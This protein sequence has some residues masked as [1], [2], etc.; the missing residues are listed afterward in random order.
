MT[1]RA[2]F[3]RITN[4]TCHNF[5]EPPDLMPTGVKSLLGLGLKYCIKAPKPTNKID[6]T[7]ERLR[8]DV[9]RIA[10]LRFNPQHE[11]P[12]TTYIPG[13]YLKTDW[14]ADPTFPEIEKCL[15]N[16][17]TEIRRTRVRYNQPTLSNLTATQ[18]KLSKSLKTH[19]EFISIEAD[20][21]LGGCFLLRDTYNSKGISEHL[22]NTQ[23]YK[24]LSKTEAV[25]LQGQLKKKIKSFAAKW[26][27]RGV[28]SKAERTY[29]HRATERDEGQFARFRMSLKAHKSPWK[30][31]PIVC[32]AGT[33]MNHLSRWLDHQLQKLKPLI[34]TYIRDS[35]QLLDLLANLGPLPP[36][37]KVFTADANSMYTNIDT[38]HAIEVINQWLDSL[39]PRLPQGFPLEAVKEAMELVMRYNVFEWG[40]M[41]FLQLSGTAMGTSAACMWATIYFA[42]REINHLI[43]VYHQSLL[44]FVRFID[45][46]LGIWIGNNEDWQQFQDDTNNFGILTWEFE[47]PSLSVDFL[48]LTI[49]IEA[50]HITTKTYQKSMNLY[51]YI[52]PTSA[53]PPG[54]M[55]GIVYG[56]MRNY[57]RQNTK[58]S[59]YYNMC[60]KLFVRHVA[61]GWEPSTMKEY[62][63]QAD[64]K[65]QAS[66]RLTPA[67]TPTTQPTIQ[68][69]NNERLFIHWEY[70]PNDIPRRHIRAIYNNNCKEVFESMLKIKQVTVAYSRPN[71]VRDRIS[72]AKLHQAP[73]REASKFY[74]G[75]LP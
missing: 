75:E 5:C 50:N 73:G 48:D 60:R 45:D 55:K 1:A 16:F 36:N 65:L 61:R 71:N 25:R 37:A 23:V 28:I 14:K 63:L 15:D 53:H 54:M 33:L 69:T 44:L 67:A 22:G 64:K 70:H 20:K 43:P 38:D 46:M 57:Y 9:R 2:Y 6:K 62:I 19:D 42:V 7:I 41:Y 3:S 24:P 30:M 58:K 32:C 51:Q 8:D 4:I 13:L 40:D 29:L 49:S 72:K 74:S 18:W 68:P 31:R 12:E 34:P 21:N 56:L 39:G 17:E 10:W 11:D 26:R 66:P 27:N 52:P 59:D 47:K 35:G